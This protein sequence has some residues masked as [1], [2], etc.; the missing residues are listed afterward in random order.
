M[1]N[2]YVT[3]HRFLDIFCYHHLQLT[4]ILSLSAAFN[5]EATAFSN[6]DADFGQYTEAGRSGKFPLFDLILHVTQVSYSWSR[7]HQ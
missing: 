7:L 1:G 6:G 3:V 2:R 4:T 5:G